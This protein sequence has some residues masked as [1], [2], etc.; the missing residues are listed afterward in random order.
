[1]KKLTFEDFLME[2]HGK[3]YV[4][5][6]D[7]MPDAYNDWIVNLSFDEWIT[8]GDLYGIER[9]LMANDRAIEILK[10]ETK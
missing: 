4:G 2:Q 8:L 6:D 1:M 10:G 9:A 7:M 3:D 5:T